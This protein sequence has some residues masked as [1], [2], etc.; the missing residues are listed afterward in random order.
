MLLGFYRT[1]FIIQD[2]IKVFLRRE[3]DNA[4]GVSAKI[5]WLILFFKVRNK[6]CKQLTP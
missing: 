4:S 2:L 3:I 6:Y 1:F 5:N